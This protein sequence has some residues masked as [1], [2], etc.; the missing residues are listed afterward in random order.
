M[1]ISVPE[2]KGEF[3]E[4]IEASE[5]A[6]YEG[7][8]AC[9]NE[10]NI[11]LWRPMVAPPPHSRPDW[12]EYLEKAD[13]TEFSIDTTKVGGNKTE[14]TIWCAKAK[15]VEDVNRPAFIFFHG[16][17]WTMYQG[18]TKVEACARACMFD[19]TV[20]GVDYG[21]APETKAPHSGLN[22]YAAVLHICK[23]AAS[24]NVDPTRIAMGGESS[25]G[26][27]TAICSYE[28][29]KNNCA[30]LIKFAWMD[31]A[32]CSNHWFERT[33]DNCRDWVEAASIPGT[34]G[35]LECFVPHGET[36]D[37]PGPTD[38]FP[39]SADVKFD[40]DFAK[41]CAEKFKDDPT[42]F[43]IAMG[44]DLARRCPPTFLT[45]REFDC[46]RRDSEEYGELMKRNKRLL[47]PVYIQPGTTHM[48][49]MNPELPGYAELERDQ[50]A[51][52]KHF[53]GN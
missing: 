47:C 45:T 23:N 15:G 33:A 40:Q 42:C 7:F 21:M 50:I 13:V 35:P 28:L 2:L 37:G 27:H 41:K 22:C 52:F 49:S 12:A 36:Y 6:Q 29:A 14:M 19:C 32:A 43:P 8:D 39:F 34:W 16:G 31:I 46:Y 20:F 17:S 10:R 44:D 3:G 11:Q 30:H 24:F 51:L 53:M 18:M 25:G 1:P 4:G 38:E 5:K 9:M 48:S 26:G